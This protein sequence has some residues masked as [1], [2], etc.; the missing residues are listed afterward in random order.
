VAQVKCLGGSIGK[1]GNQQVQPE[2]AAKPLDALKEKRTALRSKLDSAISLGSTLAGPV[3]AA[4]KFESAVAGLNSDPTQFETMKREVLELSTVIPMATDGLIDLMKAAGEKGVAHDQLKR[5]T[6]DAYR[7][8]KVFNVGGKEAVNAMTGWRAN[9]G[10]NQEQVLMLGDAYHHLS[11]KMRVADKDMLKLS[12]LAGD[13]AK[14]FGLSGEQAGALGAAFLA[15]N[16]S[17]EAADKAM[18]GLFNKLKYADK[19]DKKFKGALKNIG[20]D[21]EDLKKL[22]EQDTQGGLLKFL[23][24]VKSS[25]DVSGNLHDLFGEKQAG[26]IGKLVGGLDKYHEAMGLVGN[27]KDY[28]GSVQTSY[29]KPP[30]TTEESLQLFHNQL[31]RLGIT[32]GSVVLPA[33]NSLLGVVAPVVGTVADLAQQ[34]P[35]ATKGIVG[36]VTVLYALKLGLIASRYAWTFL[37]E[38]WLSAK[39]VLSTLKQGIGLASTKLKA[40]NATALITHVRTKALAVGGAIKGFAAS[41][42]SLAGRAI[43]MVIGG[44]RTLT[45]ALMSN[46]I[47]LIIGGIALAA[48]LI[49]TFWEPIRDFFSHLWDAVKPTIAAVW[50]GLKSILSF[51]PL[52]LIISGWSGISDFFSNLWSGIVNQATAAMD[53]L[54]G[55]FEAVAS[56]FSGAWNSFTGLLGGDDK[57]A[58][59]APPPKPA[60]KPLALAATMAVSPT[61][62]QANDA[63]IANTITPQ[64]VAATAPGPAGQVNHHHDYQIT[65]NQQPGQDPRALVDHLLRELERRQQQRRREGFGDG[66]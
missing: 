47:G 14:S 28:A 53:W 49:I 9:F 35:L 4:M 21:P 8:G 42:F 59:K 58:K 20:M 39:S 57:A 32:I 16:M 34:F 64:S 30:K 2:A 7:L 41:L 27:S 56:F 13:S 55:K 3:K 5:F 17:P 23:E 22:I 1:P 15:Q 12:G 40:F 33:F 10:L 60:L 62:A 66:I 36:L 43:P 25:G 38:G 52:G 29:E 31:N 46:P 24:A 54:I 50:E 65:I 44:L 48:G 45:L 18:K 51:T 61:V 26:N 11:K 6:Q 37:K 63:A 19:Q